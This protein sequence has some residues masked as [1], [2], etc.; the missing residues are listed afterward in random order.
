MNPN[1]STWDLKAALVSIWNI[2]DPESEDAKALFE[3][4]E[5]LIKRGSIY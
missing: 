2:R 3:K 5:S 4:A 1:S